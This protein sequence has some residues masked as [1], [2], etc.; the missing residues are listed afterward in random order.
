MAD[1]D[2]PS[3][4]FSWPLAVFLLA[5]LSV[6]FYNIGGDLMNDDEGTYLYSAWRISVGDL[7]YA[8]FT[9][10][11]TPLSFLPTAALFAVV[12]PSVP[13]ARALAYLFV[14]GAALFVYAGA[15]RF[16]AVSAW[17]AAA[18][19]GM[20][21]FTR[22]VFYLGRSFMPDDLMLLLAAGAL[23]SFLK[24]SE[25]GRPGS[26]FAAGALAGLAGLAK[27]NGALILAGLLFCLMAVPGREARSL[28]ARLKSGVW[29]AAGFGI[30]FGL[31]F[32]ALLL[33]VPG[34]AY[35]TVFFHAGKRALAEGAF[36]VRPFV[37]LGQ[38]IG[39]HNYGLIPVAAAGIVFRRGRRD[40]KTALLLCA[41]AAP[42]VVLF[43]PGRFFV[44]YVVWALIPLALLFGAGIDG[45][46]RWKRGRWAALPAALILIV[47]SLGPTFSPAKLTA[48]D[49]GTRALAAYVK[50]HT[51]PGSF[52]FGDDPFINFLAGRPCPGRLVDVS[53][54][55][56][57]GG[58]ITAEDIRRENEAARTAL[59]FVEKGH[60]AHHLV[61]L[62][63]FERFQAYLDE[64]FVKAADIKREFLD[65]E[66]YL[67][68]LP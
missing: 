31:P 30:A 35:Q 11:Q 63:D 3:R 20:F 68:R 26:F 57:K 8:D 51:P 28:A 65:V 45:L 4:R 42:F 54:A 36:F 47:L 5:A 34:A 29:A 15:R 18:A 46:V 23:F 9:L 44:R 50:E 6:G 27:L 52:V 16:L 62:P 64:K 21:L 2:L 33:F 53:E 55:W 61:A 56:T 49:K 17:G 7:P 41:A 48:Y 32:A 67:R 60:S 37:R 40:G 39:S 10:V 1:R 24:A 13:A 12:G 19:A 22:H 43:L 38:F 25:Y 66:V 58:L 59:I 14:L